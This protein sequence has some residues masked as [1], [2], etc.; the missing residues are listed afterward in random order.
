MAYIRKIKNREGKIYVYLIEGYREGDKVKSRT[1]KNFGLLEDL[2]SK[3]PGAYERLRKEAKEGKL[4]G[5]IEKTIKVEFDLKTPL[6]AP[7]KNYGWKLLNSLYQDLEL[8]KLIENY[9]NTKKFTYNLDEILKLLVFQRILKPDSKLS[10]VNS[11]KELFGDWS[12]DE[13]NIYRSLDHLESLKEEIQLKLHHEISKTTNRAATLVFYDVTNY[14]F[15]SETIDEDVLD[16][17]GNIIVKGMRKKGPSKEKRPNP[18]VQLGLFMDSNGIPISYKLFSGN[19]T[20]PITYV[21]AIEQVKKQFGIE[22]IVTVADKAMNSKKNITDAFLKGDGW[23]FSQ[24]FK[25]HRGCPKDV[26]T[27]VLEDEGWLFNESKTFAK[28][29]MIRKRELDN[30]QIVQEKVVVT[31]NKKYADREK[32][33]RKGAVEYVEKLKRPEIFQLTC[34]KGGKKYLEIY[35]IDEETGEKKPFSPF[36]EINH[37]QVEYDEQF[38]GINVL[39]TS[40]LEMTDED[41]IANYG[42]LYRIEDC[43]RVTKTELSARPI[44]VWTEKHIEAHFLTCFIALTMIRL[45]QYKMKWTLSVEKI[46]DGLK[47]AICEEMTKGYWKVWGNENLVTINETL[48]IDWT[49]QFVK[50]EELKNYSHSWFTTR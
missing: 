18:I 9:Q 15:E 27:F 38:D 49:K 44:Y 40:E 29:S 47:S 45:I 23:L 39:V 34:K 25:G 14:Y 30:K 21:P 48:Q 13:Q 24:K 17:D 31:W 41:I 16:A 37:E 7:P 20:D 1:L 4:T 46:V 2:E 33:R 42:E 11:Q 43:F 3:E 22:R 6:C 28:K 5:D 8:S 26:Q 36:F 35:A 19:Q 12:V 32:V 50:Y 10:T